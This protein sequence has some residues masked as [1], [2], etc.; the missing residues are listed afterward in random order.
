MYL[1]HTVHEYTSAYNYKMFRTLDL[2][3]YH[4]YI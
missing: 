1:K 4:L 2:F 3:I